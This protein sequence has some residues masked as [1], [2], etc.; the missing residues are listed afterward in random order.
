MFN[1][2]FD[3]DTD[4]EEGFSL[5]ELMIVI[6][7]MG[8]LASIVITTFITKRD[9]IVDAG[10]TTNIEQIEQEI[11]QMEMEEGITTP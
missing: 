7:I 6:A 8:T 5:L 10:I 9:D 3:T 1:F 2:N 4:R 11:E